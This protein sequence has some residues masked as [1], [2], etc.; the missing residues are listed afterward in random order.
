MIR[1]KMPI[2]VLLLVSLPVFFLT[3]LY[4][5]YISDELI[6]S[7][8]ERMKQVLDITVSNYES[9]FAER[10]QEVVYLSKNELV[11]ELF[12][13]YDLLEENDSINFRMDNVQLNAFFNEVNENQQYIRD[14][15]VLSPYGMVLS[16]TA[17]ESLWIDLSDR[18]YFLD[19]MNGITTISNLLVD[20]IRN[21]SVIFIAT[22]VKRTESDE[23]IGVMAEIIDMKIKSDQLRQL[24]DPGIGDAYLI[25]NKSEIVFHT[26]KNLIGSLPSNDGIREYF[27]SDG[28]K[29]SEGS[30][31][32]SEGTQKMFFTYKS[33][34]NTDWKLVIEQDMGIITASAYRSLGY[35]VVLSLVLLTIAFT[36]AIRFTYGITR[37]L[38]QLADVMKSATNGDLSARST[39]ISSNELGQ[40][41]MDLNF[42]LNK[43]ETSQNEL[44]DI[45]EKY[46]LAINN[47]RDIIWEWDYSKNHFFASENWT[48]LT[49]KK[50]F[51][52][53]VDQIV[54]EEILTDLDK[55]R[56]SQ[57]VNQLLKDEIE[58][59]IMDF[60]YQMDNGQ[61]KWFTIKA[62]ILKEKGETIKI[63]GTLVDNTLKKQSEEKIWRLAYTNQITNVPNKLAFIERIESIKSDSNGSLKKFLVLI[64]DIYNLK[65]INNLFGHDVGD[66]ILKELANRLHSQYSD[67]YHLS[68]DEFAVLIVD[69]PEEDFI[70]KEIIHIFSMIH[71]PMLIQ[72]RTFEISAYIGIS[73]YPENG[74]SATEL[75]QNADTAL[76]HAKSLGKS[77][78]SFFDS[79]MT[80]KIVKKAEIEGIL[81]RAVQDGLISMHFQ[82]LY[83]TKS[84]K[85]VGFEALMRIQLENGHFIPPSDF[86]HVAEETGDILELGEWALEY[87][88]KKQ[89]E[90]IAKGYVVEKISLNVSSVQLNQKGFLDAVKRITKKYGIN[91]RGICFEIT[92]SV[93]MNAMDQTISD[94][95]I[96]RE[97]GFEIAI[98]DFGTGYSSF[99]YLNKLPIDYLK[100]DK[101]FI[102]QIAFNFKD[103]HLLKQII[104][105]AQ[106][107]MELKI[108][109]E[110]VE[111]K[112]QYD[113]LCD[114][115]CDTI[116]GYYF[117]RPLSADKCDE[118][119]GAVSST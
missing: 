52:E 98:D 71:T 118:L 119:L 64:I 13:R 59:L 15:F 89:V 19:A 33:I 83:A 80:E 12:Y 109:A 36:V 79:L 62:S 111:S 110:G 38:T 114:F 61:K 32:I 97:M 49:G 68:G 90:W 37:P 94:L 91:P 29:T 26:D 34:N 2:I 82:P 93:M 73:R 81:K 63:S 67:C 117:S 107:V 14:L 88:F 103:K 1:K 101:C 85:L 78:Y 11:Q 30:M 48:K 44:K 10:K 43:L 31:L 108:I 50:S 42:M 95:Q 39:Y 72:N 54:F 40:L 96:L 106:Q 104:E 7:N 21:E 47:S 17:P 28:M 9:F 41:S 4:Y 35:M 100:V 8:K 58:L 45:Q 57:L 22:P 56:I 60:E 77:N 16:S 5:L 51:K 105:I 23:V 70:V 115:D 113:I 76:Y 112:E 3:T 66:Q 46:S 55:K 84:K 116:Q 99:N 69:E 18:Q 102:D 65:Q 75:I 27:L 74:N 87:V 6:N 92:E 20:R 25:N 86:I 24:I 53:E